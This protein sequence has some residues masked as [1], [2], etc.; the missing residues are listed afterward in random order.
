M[1]E[2]IYYKTAEEAHQSTLK[3]EGPF[4]PLKKP[5]EFGGAEVWR[6]F[7]QYD[8]I[9]SSAG[10]IYKIMPAFE[11]PQGVF[12]ESYLVS[13]TGRPGV[14]VKKYVTDGKGRKHRIGGS[15]TPA[16]LIALCFIPTSL[17]M[18]S[19]ETHAYCDRRTKPTIDTVVWGKAGINPFVAE[20]KRLK[21]EMKTGEG[22]ITRNSLPKALQEALKAPKEIAGIKQR[23]SAYNTRTTAVYYAQSIDELSRITFITK[24]FIEKHLASGSNDAIYG[25][26]FTRY[27]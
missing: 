11:N 16:R 7:E 3:D 1:S 21:A 4:P 14:T 6:R 9:V 26:I 12:V 24:R 8:V 17:P 5:T 15:Y 2:P 19:E 13:V 22:D 10:E 20:E 23:F 27:F 25:F 18:H